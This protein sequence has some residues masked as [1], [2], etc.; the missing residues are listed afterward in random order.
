ME[1]PCG[2]PAAARQRM[3][4]DLL[5]SSTAAAESGAVPVLCM[6]THPDWRACAPVPGRG[7]D[8]VG[9][10]P[11][12]ATGSR[13]SSDPHGKLTDAS[14]CLSDLVCLMPK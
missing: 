12:A 3:P 6:G 2:P 13:W 14:A 9:P 10:K 5:R 11:S 1:H 7:F 8:N 4:Q